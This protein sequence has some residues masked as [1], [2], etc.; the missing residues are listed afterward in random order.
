MI[1]L[2]FY[3]FM[4]IYKINAKKLKTRIQIYIVDSVSYLFIKKTK[5]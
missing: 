3:L 1:N 4:N 5:N 2:K